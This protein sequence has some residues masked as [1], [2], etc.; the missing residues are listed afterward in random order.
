MISSL[1]EVLVWMHIWEFFTPMNHFKHLSQFEQ[2]VSRNENP[3]ES[4]EKLELGFPVPNA[5]AGG[6]DLRITRS[7]ACTTADTVLS[8]L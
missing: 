1:G 2:F 7:Q 3:I 6:A 4:I 5:K 8:A